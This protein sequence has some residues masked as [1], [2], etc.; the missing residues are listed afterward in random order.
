MQTL[1][2]TSAKGKHQR[3]ESAKSGPLRIF[4]KADIRA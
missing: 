3:Q 1:A 2:G 4:L